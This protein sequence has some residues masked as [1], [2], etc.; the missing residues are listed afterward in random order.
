MPSSKPPMWRDDIDAL[1]FQPADHR[2]ICMVHRRAFRTLLRGGAVAAAMRGLLHYTSEGISGGGPRKGASR[3]RRGG[4][5]TSTS[6]A[7]M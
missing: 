5:Q 4:P 3:K 6:P 7:G 2:G 1:A